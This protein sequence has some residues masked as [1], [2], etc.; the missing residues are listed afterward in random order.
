MFCQL[1][2]VVPYKNPTTRKSIVSG[3]V[4]PTHINEYTMSKA[5]AKSTSLRDKQLAFN[6]GG[7]GVCSVAAAPDIACT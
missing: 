5:S 1:Q 6:Q 7:F 3:P 2:I 4:D